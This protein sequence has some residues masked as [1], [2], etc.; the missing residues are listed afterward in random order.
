MRSAYRRRRIRGTLSPRSGVELAKVEE[1]AS[2]ERGR[3]IA[4]IS[5]SEST[6]KGKAI[7]VTACTT[8][9]VA[10]K[11]AFKEVEGEESFFLSR[12]IWGLGDIKVVLFR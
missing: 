3:E 8:S 1:I 10:S 11:S 4:E 7:A 9:E 12:R 5:E 6:S 2:V